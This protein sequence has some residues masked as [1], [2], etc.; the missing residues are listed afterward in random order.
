MVLLPGAVFALQQKSRLVKITFSKVNFH[1]LLLI[2]SPAVAG[3]E[4]RADEEGKNTE[5]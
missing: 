3:A 1:V 4:E 2:V 5:R